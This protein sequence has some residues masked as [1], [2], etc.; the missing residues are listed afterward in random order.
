[1]LFRFYSAV[2]KITILD[3]SLNIPSIEFQILFFKSIENQCI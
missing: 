2:K 3:I 1:M